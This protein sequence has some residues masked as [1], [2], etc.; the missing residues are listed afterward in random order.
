MVY[1]YSGRYVAQFRSC[2]T[3]SRYWGPAISTTSTVNS[4][5]VNLG[6]RCPHPSDAPKRPLMVFRGFQFV[7]VDLNDETLL[8]TAKSKMLM[9][10][11]RRHPAA[12]HGR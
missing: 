2:T 9:P 10:M 12:S 1:E 3:G 5:S 8:I 7:D 11:P 6:N 4:R